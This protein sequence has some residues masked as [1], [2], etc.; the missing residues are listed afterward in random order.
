MAAFES[1]RGQPSIG[2]S[3]EVAAA[4]HAA[5]VGR[6]FERSDSPCYCQ[7]FS[8]SGDNR[9]WQ[10]R[11]ALTREENERALRAQLEAGKIRAFVALAQGEVIGWMRLAQPSS[12]EKRYQ[13]RLYRGLPCLEGD[14]HGVWSVVCFLVRPDVR[15]SGVARKLLEC[16]LSWA[17]D[18]RAAAIEAFPRGATDVT[19]EEQFTGPES[20]YV[21]MGF[22]KV[23]DFAPYPVFRYSFDRAPSA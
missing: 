13:G 10:M 23:H 16:G 12:L 11:C 9:E 4:E 7:Y 5:G 17:R 21:E 8:F 2:V 18:A 22:D 3:V 14:R 1:D 15:R 20:L 6:L 19:D